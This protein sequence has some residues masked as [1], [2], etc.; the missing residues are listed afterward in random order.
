MPEAQELGYGVEVWNRPLGWASRERG[1]LGV[2]EGMVPS[3]AY[4]R[5]LFIGCVNHS[6]SQIQRIQRAHTGSTLCPERKKN[7]KTPRT[8][9][10]EK[11][12]ESNKVK[13]SLSQ[14]RGKGGI[15]TGQEKG[16]TGLLTTDIE[17]EG[18]GIFKRFE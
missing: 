16:H 10:Q 4:I 15:H 2:L 17:R 5:R 12:P 3:T 13:I 8:P 6:L 18:G 1:E 11:P 7:D 9:P 14:G